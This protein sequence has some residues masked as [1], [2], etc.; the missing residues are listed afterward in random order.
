MFQFIAN[1]S[2]VCP[3]A[4]IVCLMLC[5]WS[6]GI[7][8]RDIKPENIFINH[9][10][11]LLK[12][13]DFGLARFIEDK[14]TTCKPPGGCGGATPSQPELSL[15]FPQHDSVVSAKGLV[16]GT[17]G[18]T[19]PE[20]GALCTEKVDVFSAALIL[21]ELLCPRFG[22]TMERHQTLENFR[23]RQKVSL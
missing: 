23:T 18:Y 10:P 9:N 17:P 6:R 16:I 20:G 22:T 3:D 19:A 14:I 1:F 15:E 12:I 13:G 7:V 8:H 11:L 5:H 2:I 21:L 4:L